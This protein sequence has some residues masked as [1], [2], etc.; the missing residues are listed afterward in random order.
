MVRNSR[1]EIKT[2]KD[3]VYTEKMFKIFL[4]KLGVY[5][6]YENNLKHEIDIIFKTTNYYS[7]LSR[8]FNW[9]STQEGDSFWRNIHILWIKYVQKGEI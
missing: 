7:Y 9:A 8:S 5:E 4:N 1:N 6:K 3:Y 2:M